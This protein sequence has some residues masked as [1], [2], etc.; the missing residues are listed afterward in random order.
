MPKLNTA[1][2]SGKKV[3]KTLQHYDTK[4]PRTSAT[5]PMLKKY[6]SKAGKVNQ[7]TSKGTDLF[8]NDEEM[9]LLNFFDKA[10]L[11][12][13]GLKK[14]TDEHILD[15][16]STRI[17]W[18][19]KDGIDAR[20][21]PVS[22]AIYMPDAKTIIAMN[23]VAKNDMHYDSTTFD[24]IPISEIM[25]LSWVD[26]AQQLDSQASNL[27]FIIQHSVSGKS[28]ATVIELIN[29]MGI[30]EPGHFIDRPIELTGNIDDDLV[31]YA[32]LGCDNCKSMIYTLIDHR[33][34]LGGRLVERIVVDVNESMCLLVLSDTP[35]RTPPTSS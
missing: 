29:K 34:Q 10:P 33:E 17:V 14:P 35:P 26:T 22:D 8:K 30:A 11:K 32:L 28:G 5:F 21:A 24:R 18:A 15:S 9:K 16:S 6:Y 20:D 23:S 1:V 27:K 7:R 3:F 4:V 19:N 12:I 31:L 2:E 25:W 13:V